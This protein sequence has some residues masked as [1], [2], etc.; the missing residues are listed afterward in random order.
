MKIIQIN[1]NRS[2]DAHSL[3]SQKIIEEKADICLVSEPN[4]ELSKEWGGDED[5]KI[6][7]VDKG[8]NIKNREHGK[9]W[10][11]VVLQDKVILSVY[12]SPNER[13][14][15][16]RKIIMEIYDVIQSEHGKDIIIGGDFNAK[17]K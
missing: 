15:N 6:L 8:L 12:V 3:L 1:L 11:A 2:R 17:A 16:I 10:T 13:D 5:A 7:I 14:D 4:K 9:E